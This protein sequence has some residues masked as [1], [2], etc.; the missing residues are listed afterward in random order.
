MK[1]GAACARFSPD[2]CPAC[3]ALAVGILEELEEIRIRAQ[4]DHVVPVTEALLVS[5][6]TA[7]ERVELGILVVRVG[8]GAGRLGITFTADLFRLAIG[9]CQYFLA[10]AVGV[11]ANLLGL[12][13]TA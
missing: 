2:V 10:L 7:V 12:L 5:A 13:F 9:F 11:G 4:Q 6:Q 3:T 1:T 8:L